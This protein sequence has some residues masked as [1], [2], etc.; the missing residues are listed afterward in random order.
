[1]AGDGRPVDRPALTYAA[2]ATPEGLKAIRAYAGAI[3]VETAMIVPRGPDGASLPATSLIPDA[4]AAGLKV[5]SWTFRAENAFLPTELR[6][7]EGHGRS[8]RSRRA[9]QVVPRSGRRR[10]LLGLPRDRGGRVH[11][12]P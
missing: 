3:G 7:G 10:G 11:L 5:V 6:R 9:T 8:R 1:M 2:M 12:R 4:H